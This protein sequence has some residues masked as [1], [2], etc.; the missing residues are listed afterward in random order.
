ME[1]PQSPFKRSVG[2]V[3]VIIFLVAVTAAVAVGAAL[4]DRR[5]VLAAVAAVFFVG[6]TVAGLR[7]RRRR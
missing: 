4:A 1:Q 3:G 6:A 7:V 2:L 5:Y